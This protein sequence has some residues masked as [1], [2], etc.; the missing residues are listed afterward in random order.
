M[1]EALVALGAAAIGATAGLLGAFISA[2]QQR[3]LD[4]V[5]FL[6]ERRAE[7]NKN[8]RLAVAELARALSRVLQTMNWFTWEA[9]NRPSR[10]TVEWVDQYDADMK[11]LLPDLMGAIAIVAALSEPIYR[12]FDPLVSE[13]FDLDARIGK[14]ASN[15]ATDAAATRDQIG[16]LKEPAFTLFRRFRE[17]LAVVMGHHGNSPHT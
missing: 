6:Q 15:L 12:A 5:R 1:S 13:A 10:V 11:T 4:E 9:D 7:D 14:A 17:Q 16:S 3:R 2:R 8:E